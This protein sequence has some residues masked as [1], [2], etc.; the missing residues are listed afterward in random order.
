MDYNENL[1]N[2]RYMVSRA[3][4]AND[5]A[6]ES[7]IQCNFT[8]DLVM[9]DPTTEGETVVIQRTSD[10][11]IRVNQKGE[12]FIGC[13]SRE[14]EGDDGAKRYV[15]SFTAYPRVPGEDNEAQDERKDGFVKFVLGL[16]KEQ[17]AQQKAAIPEE[18]REL[19]EL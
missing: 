4:K 13:I 18:V 7:G 14:W 9:D 16:I 19:Q 1:K 6:R 5:K 8:L 10:L 17:I 11:S 2:A 3:V 15:R 12:P